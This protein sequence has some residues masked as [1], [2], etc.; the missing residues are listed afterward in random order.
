MAAAMS[1]PGDTVAVW[2]ADT[3]II[4]KEIIKINM[5]DNGMSVSCF[6]DSPIKHAKVIK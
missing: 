6:M 5:I 1:S 2:A 3:G 4:I